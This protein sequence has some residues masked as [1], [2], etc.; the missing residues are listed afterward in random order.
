MKLGFRRGQRKGLCQ[1]TD[2][3]E[4]DAAGR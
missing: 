2:K 3:V 4:T 1:T